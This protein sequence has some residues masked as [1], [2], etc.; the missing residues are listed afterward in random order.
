MTP[1]QAILAALN[2]TEVI[3]AAGMAFRF[4]FSSRRKQFA[5]S[6]NQVPLDSFPAEHGIST[7]EQQQQQQEP[8][9]QSPDFYD[10]PRYGTANGGASYPP[11]FQAEQPAAHSWG[12]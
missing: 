4:R 9:F 8:E 1:T 12:R 2:P 10:P 3:Q 6:E 7:R 11:V 5:L